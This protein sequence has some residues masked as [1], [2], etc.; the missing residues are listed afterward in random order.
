MILIGL[1]ALL[2]SV[3]R[4]RLPPALEAE[5]KERDLEGEPPERPEPP[6]GDRSGSQTAP[7]PSRGLSRWGALGFVVLG[8]SALQLCD[9]TL[10]GAWSA[11]GLGFVLGVARWRAAAADTTPRP[12]K[13]TQIAALRAAGRL[14]VVWFYALPLALPS[15]ILLVRARTW[16][17]F[18]FSL[19]CVLAPVSLVLALGGRRLAAKI[20]LATLV[21]LG[22]L[23]WAA[24]PRSAPGKIESHL[25]GGPAP[26]SW[27]P[28][29][30][31]PEEDQFQL[32][33]FFLPPTDRFVDWEQSVR[34]RRVFGAVYDRAGR[35]PDLAGL[36]GIMSAT[37]RDVVGAELPRHLYVYAPPSPTPRP[38]ILFLHGSLG[39]FQGYLSALKGLADQEGL[40]IVSV[41]FGSGLWSRA[42]GL[43]RIE[44]ALAFVASDPRLDSQGVIAVGISAGGV[45]ASRAGA[46]FPDRLRGLALLSPVIEPELFAETWRKRPVLVVHGALDRRI[47]QAYVDGAVAELKQAGVR[48]SYVLVPN[49]DHFLYFSETATV[50]AALATWIRGVLRSGGG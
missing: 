50:N 15:L 11:L 38:V 17:G 35:D 9:Y 30:L 1:R 8:V 28:A 7:V 13:R 37:Y 36:P 45:A 47:P 43:A 42:G 49:E 21:S 32:G 23:L 20:T 6:G 41:S 40:A 31:V 18:S 5:A 3:A 10:V 24:V 22:L 29:A 4:F 39:S 14:D 44:E 19:L 26:S 16:Q 2:K 27:T 34:V 46:A 48:V 12:D 33:T 25:L